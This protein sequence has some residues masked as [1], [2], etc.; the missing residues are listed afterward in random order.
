MCGFTV[1]NRKNF[2]VEYVDQ[3][4][5]L[6][7]PDETTITNVG[8]VTIVHHL[9]SLTGKYQTQ[10]FLDDGLICV[11][12]GEIYN[13]REFG[14]YETDGECLI[15]LYREYGRDFTRKLEGEF[16]IVIIDTKNNKIDA[17]RD[18]FGT[19]PC[20]VAVEG[21]EFAFSSYASSIE[22]LG[23]S[24]WETP[25]KTKY[26]FSLIQFKDSYDDWI[27]AFERAV[28]KRL[29]DK[30]MFIGLSSGYDSGAIDCA[31]KNLKASYTALTIGD[32]HLEGRD[33][34]KIPL[35]G[36]PWDIDMS[37]I[38][39]EFEYPIARDI[40]SY[41]QTQLFKTAKEKAFK[42]SISGHGADEVMWGY[43]KN[44]FASHNQTL[45]NHFYGKKQK[46][47]LGKEERISGGHGIESRYPFLD[48]EVVQE[49][50]WLTPQL[51]NKYFKA[52]I[53]EYLTRNN[54]PFEAG[55]KRGFGMGIKGQKLEKTLP[56]DSNEY[57]LF[58]KI[59]GI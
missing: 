45:G 23:F 56:K 3:Y 33:S 4:T 36:N 55:V 22:R 59:S 1:T 37:Y 14:D 27:D 12:N 52:P 47:F 11:F 15:P 30:R 16:C 10:P 32:E 6:R 25:S 24:K 50:L 39:Q 28:K 35:P 18:I 57:K 51:K 5:R 7:G 2:N 17:F 8:D 19:K 31:L 58:D 9:L 38:D 41:G 21:N 46:W 43:K 29:S 34:L 13:Y 40:A 42:I 20:Y 26:D 53:H 49:Y 44:Y 54:Y 48:P